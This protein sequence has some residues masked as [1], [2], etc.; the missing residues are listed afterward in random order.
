[1]ILNRGGMKILVK[2]LIRRTIIVNVKGVNIATGLKEI[3]ERVKELQQTN[4]DLFLQER[5]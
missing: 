5:S 1:M 2:I 3:L 4:K